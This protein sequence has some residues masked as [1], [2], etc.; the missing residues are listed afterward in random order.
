[1]GGAARDYA[2]RKFA[3]Q[4]IL[5]ALRDVGRAGDAHRLVNVAAAAQRVADG[6]PQT[7]RRSSEGFYLGGMVV[8][9]VLELEQPFLRLAVHIH[10][11]VDGAGVVLLA[12][13]QVVKPSVGTQPAGADGGEVHQAE[14]FLLTAKF[15]AHL[16]PHREGLLQLIADEGILHGD[17]GK[18]R[19][20]CCVTAMVAP[21][22]VE[23]A[24]LRL[25]GVAA[26]GLEIVH[27]L[28]EVV[29][30]HGETHFAA[31]FRSLVGS[32][33]PQAFEHL[34]RIGVGAL[35][36]MQHIEVLTAGLHGV[37]AISGNLLYV[38]RGD[39]GVE[40]NQFGSCYLHIGI[41]LK[42]AH[43]LACR[44][45][46]LVELSRKG[47]VGE[48]RSPRQIQTVADAVGGC[49]SEYA[50]AGLLQESGREAEQVIDGKKPE[51][52]DVKAEV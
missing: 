5:H 20:E 26:L 47:L 48:M 50:P 13:L 31:V 39:R 45:R 25:V 40:S 30:I 23:D 7:C 32:D 51:F 9:L 2:L 33:F 1:M 28:H 43:A 29:S 41:R 24:E 34:H 42:K 11:D 10:V 21:I 36:K 52:L 8:G 6:T 15:A 35:R 18:K 17:I 44:C 12:L 22:C 14:R 46:T 19:G 49:L 4:R 16:F 3:G 27:H 37:D 38:G